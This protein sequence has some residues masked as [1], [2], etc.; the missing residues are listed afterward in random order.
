[1]VAVAVLLK[2][3][4]VQVQV[5]LVVEA[6]EITAVKQTEPLDKALVVVVLTVD[7]VVEAVEQVL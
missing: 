1:L 7:V 6:V 3:K 5:G 4:Q 2:D